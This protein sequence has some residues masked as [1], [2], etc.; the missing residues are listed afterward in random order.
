VS[1]RLV[2]RGRWARSL[3]S[4]VVVA[5]IVANAAPAFAAGTSDGGPPSLA[6]L[7]EAAQR[8]Q[9]LNDRVGALT[10]RVALLQDRVDGTAVLL[11][12]AADAVARR[13]AEFA[14]ARARFDVAAESGIRPADAI[15]LSE[16]RNG[17]QESKRELAR[18]MR[19]TASQRVI[20]RLAHAQEALSKVTARRD[21]VMSAVTAMEAQ[22]IAASGDVSDMTTYGGWAKGLLGALGAPACLNNVVSVVAWESA[23]STTAVWNPLATTLRAPGSTPYN[24]AGVQSYPSAAVGLAATIDTLRYGADEYGYGSI[25]N[26]LAACAAPGDTALAINASM[27][28]RGCAGGAYVLNQV[29]AVEA[30]LPAYANR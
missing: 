21:A 6:S 8:L 16:A 5:W 9:A 20:P 7:T 23:E 25:L 11:Q 27:W 22:V 13:T 28:C 2:A 3:A 4:A 18:R 19:S 24:G 10:A 29:A 17:V 15:R 30:D 1:R 14:V 12:Q 26:G